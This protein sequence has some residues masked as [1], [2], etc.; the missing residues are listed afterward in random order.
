MAKIIHTKAS[1]VTKSEVLS[2]LRTT[3]QSFKESYRE[4]D[5]KVRDLEALH[6]IACHQ[7]A[8]NF[9]FANWQS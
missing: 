2:E 7:D 1:E 8:Y 4:A 9:I 6:A 5:G 3:L